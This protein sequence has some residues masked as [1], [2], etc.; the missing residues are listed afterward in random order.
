VGI[1]VGLP[2]AAW[3]VFDAAW[4]IFAKETRARRALWPTFHI[5]VVVL[6]VNFIVILL[7]VVIYSYHCHTQGESSSTP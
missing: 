4:K 5:N 6:I 2:A 3:L 7:F 1:V